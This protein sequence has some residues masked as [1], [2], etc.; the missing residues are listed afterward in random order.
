MSAST[1]VR[2]TP[3][4]WLVCLQ[5]VVLISSR[6]WPAAALPEPVTIALGLAL[7][8]VLAVAWWLAPRR[9]QVVEARWLVAPRVPVGE[10]VTVGAQLAVT[11][12]LPPCTIEALNPTTRKREPAVRLRALAAGNQ[13]STWVVRFP[14]RG[15]LTLPPLIMRSIQPFGVVAVERIIGPGTEVVVLPPIGQVRR[16]LRERL[17]TWLAELSATNDPGSDELDRLR[18]YR[19]GDPLRAIHWRASARHGELLV[20]ERTDPACR[21]LAIVLDTSGRGASGPLE[22]RRFEHLVAAAATLAAACL[23]KGWQVTVHGGFAPAGLTGDLPR[24]LEG[25]ALATCD[26]VALIDCLPP[27]PA[28]AVLTA[29]PGDVPLTERPP[30]IIA[31]ERIDELM[32]LP[33]RMR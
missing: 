5:A 9:A 2:M 8:A 24:L 31:L 21:R 25:L 19:A 3:V 20:A 12:N 6:W 26:G 27:Q 22:P 28:V 29:R 13:R 14:R 4:G 30:L 33:T 7:L 23:E 18:D 10:E 11:G 16:A 32:R 15:L 17:D 1:V